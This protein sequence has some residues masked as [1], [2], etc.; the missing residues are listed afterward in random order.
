MLGFGTSAGAAAGRRIR[1]QGVVQSPLEL[2]HFAD[3]GDSC[4]PIAA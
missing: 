1:Y 2:S 4:V 3:S